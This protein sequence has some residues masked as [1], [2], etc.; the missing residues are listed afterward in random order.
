MSYT[1][2]QGESNIFVVK[3]VDRAEEFFFQ[4]G[5]DFSYYNKDLKQVY[6]SSNEN[7]T[8]W[9]GNDE[10]DEDD[11]IEF[12]QDILE[13]GEVFKYK[14]VTI[15]RDVYGFGICITKTDVN[16]VDLDNFLNNFN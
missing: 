11:L 16:S 1:Q 13:D 14:E 10:I 4:Y 3:D 8:I 15:D 2:I 9:G 12:I 6:I 7:T 5:F